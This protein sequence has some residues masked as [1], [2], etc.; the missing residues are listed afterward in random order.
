M[1][2]DDQVADLRRQIDELESVGSLESKLIELKEGGADPDSEELRR[3]KHELRE[4]RQAQRTGRAPATA[5]PAAI[6][7]S[8]EGD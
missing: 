8:V 2:V 4:A 1:S 7:A 5:D 3:V 6:E